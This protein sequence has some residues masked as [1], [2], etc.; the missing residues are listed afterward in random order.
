MFNNYLSFILTLSSSILIAIIVSSFESHYSQKSNRPRIQNGDLFPNLPWPFF[1]ALDNEQIICGGAII[2]KRFIITA[3]SCVNNTVDEDPPSNELKI[4]T[5]SNSL[6]DTEVNKTIQLVAK[7]PCV[8]T[9]FTKTNGKYYDDF[10]LLF[11]NESLEFNDKKIQ[12]VT[13]IPDPDQNNTRWYE[14]ADCWVVGL[15]HKIVN[16]TSARVILSDCPDEPSNESV[17]CFEYYYQYTKSCEGDQ[18]NP[19]VCRNGDGEF[20]FMGTVS[21]FIDCQNSDEQD[22]AWMKYRV[23]RFQRFYETSF[24]DCVEWFYDRWRKETE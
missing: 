16:I 3:A 22:T 17:F 6:S 23:A 2:H 14:N 7:P 1:V 19:V 10:A 8:I 24:N 12:P 9:S 15:D 21:S 13:L 5:G 4:R 11:L 20:Q 18:G